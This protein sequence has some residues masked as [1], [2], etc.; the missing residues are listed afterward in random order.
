MRD[1]IAHGYDSI[2]LSVVWQVVKVDIPDLKPQ[3]QQ[4]LKDYSDS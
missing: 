2:N 1:R 3:I 4:I